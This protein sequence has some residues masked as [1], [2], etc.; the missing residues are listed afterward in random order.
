MKRPDLE[1]ARGFRAECQR[2]GIGTTPN[3][4]DW[5]VHLHGPVHNAGWVEANRHLKADILALTTGSPEL[6]MDGDVEP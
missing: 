5:R 2:R 1:A 4:E 3:R 6:Y